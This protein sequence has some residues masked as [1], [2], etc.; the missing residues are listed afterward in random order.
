MF[1]EIYSNIT[2]KLMVLWVWKSALLNTMCRVYGAQPLTQ[3]PFCPRLV[4]PPRVEQLDQVETFLNILGSS[5]LMMHSTIPNYIAG[6]E[7]HLP[8]CTSNSVSFN[9]IVEA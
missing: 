9:L 6:L 5:F 4:K 2:K 1:F 7:L 8:L 3:G